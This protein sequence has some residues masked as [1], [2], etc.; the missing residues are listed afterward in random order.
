LRFT[1]T[2]LCK[3]LIENENDFYKTLDYTSELGRFLPRYYGTMETFLKDNSNKKIQIS[4]NLVESIEHFVQIP[5]KSLNSFNDGLYSPVNENPY[6]L[7]NFDPITQSFSQSSSLK[8]PPSPP[9][10]PPRIHKELENQDSKNLSPE[11]SFFFIFYFYIFFSS[12][13]NTNIT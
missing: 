4:T 5:T 2:T 8:S 11:S 13:L 10:S 7:I 6:S 3:I 1:P 9:S 12:N